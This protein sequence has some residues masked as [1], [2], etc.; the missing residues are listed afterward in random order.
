VV[1]A[2]SA[3]VRAERAGTVVSADGHVVHSRR[4]GVI[5]HRAVPPFRGVHVYQGRR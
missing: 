5:L 4:A 1:V 3:V 2:L